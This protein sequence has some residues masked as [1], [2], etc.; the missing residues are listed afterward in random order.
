MFIRAINFL[1]SLFTKPELCSSGSCLQPIDQTIVV[2]ENKLK[3]PFLKVRYIYNATQEEKALTVDAVNI[4]NRVYATETFKNKILASNCTETQNLN[5]EA[6]W[7]LISK[8]VTTI[9]VEWFT[10]NWRQNHI[11]KTVGYDVGDGTAYIN[12]YF[13]K[14]PI[15]LGSLITHEAIGHGNGFTHYQNKAT[16]FPY[17]LNTAFEETAAHLGIKI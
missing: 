5:P 7:E 15:T 16:S 3:H 6:I 9:K 2:T 13:V 10:G 11:Y 4:C 1:K 12:R 14:D 17:F 8:N